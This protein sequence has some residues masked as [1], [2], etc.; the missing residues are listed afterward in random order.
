MPWSHC[1]LP[2]ILDTEDCP[3]CGVNKAEWTIQAEATRVFQIAARDWIELELLDT[4]DRPLAGER[5]VVTNAKG[6]V[7]KRYKPEN[8]KTPLERLTQLAA[9]SLITF[10]PGVTLDALQAQAKSQSDLE[11]AQ[12]MRRAKR[13]LFASFVKPRRRA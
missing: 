7:V 4:F 12:A 13:D 10:K 8:V 5:F 3:T 6:K 2:F 1:D 9:Q 11:A